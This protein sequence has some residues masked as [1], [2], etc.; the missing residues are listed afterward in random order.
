MF[1]LRCL[2]IFL[3]AQSERQSPEIYAKECEAWRLVRASHQRS[4]GR[5]RKPTVVDFRGEASQLLRL[6]RLGRGGLIQPSQEFVILRRDLPLFKLSQH[7]VRLN[8]ETKLC[9][10]GGGLLGKLR[11]R[12]RHLW[13][14]RRRT[15]IT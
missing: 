14:V 15:L 4:R 3:R 1:C 9:C 7:A 13:K 10:K 5:R 2:L 11:P 6:Q 8:I 12:K